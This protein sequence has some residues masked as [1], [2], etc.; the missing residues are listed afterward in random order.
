[1]RYCGDLQTVLLWIQWS[2]DWHMHVKK[3]LED[4]EAYMSIFTVSKYMKDKLIKLHG[5]INKST[6]I[7]G[8]INTF[9][10]ITD[11]T[12]RQKIINDIVDLNNSIKQRDL[13][14]IYITIP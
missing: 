2:N 8:G 6:V 10:S 9:P 7:I 3:L 4:K 12:N 13:I 11:R 5:E 14:D 1:M